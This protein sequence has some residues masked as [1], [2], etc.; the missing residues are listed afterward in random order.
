MLA[1]A[2]LINIALQELQGAEAVS[3]QLLQ[4][5]HEVHEGQLS[6]LHELQLSQVEQLSVLHEVQPSVEHEGQ[7][8][9]VEQPE[10]PQ[11]SQA[12]LVSQVLQPQ[13]VG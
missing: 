5:S 6:V 9:Q 4:L 3:P 7:L 12:G 1:G 8:L 10:V 11:L 2:D 13:L